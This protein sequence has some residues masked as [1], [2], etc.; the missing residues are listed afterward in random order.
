[1]KPF[2]AFRNRPSQG[3][4][5]TFGH[6]YK[7]S[8]NFSTFLTLYIKRR[9]NPRLFKKCGR[10]F[11]FNPKELGELLSSRFPP[12]GSNLDDGYAHFNPVPPSRRNWIK[13]AYCLFRSPLQEKRNRRVR[14]GILVYT[15]YTIY[16]FF[17]FP[18]R[19]SPI[20]EKDTFD[21]LL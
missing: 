7:L 16:P 6:F 12:G 4:N 2:S 15:I 14:G 8:F 1:M 20:S 21:K 11:V 18:Y 17:F 13:L 5:V 19:G 3:R 10:I 9:K